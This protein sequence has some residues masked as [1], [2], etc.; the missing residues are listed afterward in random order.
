MSLPQPGQKPGENRLFAILPAPSRKRLQAVA[1][2][3][4]LQFGM[5]LF[6]EG[7]QITHVYFPSRGVV[8]LIVL[9]QDGRGVDAGSVG[10]EGMVG[11]PLVLAEEVSPY[12]TTVQ[13]EGEALQI[14]ACDFLEVLNKDEALREVLLRYVE[15]LLVQTS[16]NAACNQLHQV[17]QRLARW[18]LQVHDWLREDRFHIT[19][20][21]LALMLG[22]RRATV[23]QAAGTLQQAGLIAYQRGD[24]TIADRAGLEDIVCEDYAAIR[25]AVEH[26]LTSP[27]PVAEAAMASAWSHNSRHLER[28]RPPLSHGARLLKSVE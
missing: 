14:P 12:E 2:R 15:V 17:E 10:C 24:I 13:V 20:D 27:S 11:V 9:M 16:R 8:S 26:L 23:T 5:R 3:V 7:D 21:F 4:P 1:R 25:D 28:D 6:R 19:Q 18:L 22:V